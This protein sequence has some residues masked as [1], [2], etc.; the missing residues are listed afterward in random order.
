MSDIENG[1]STPLPI[2]VEPNTQPVKRY[3]ST[4][5]YGVGSSRKP[6]KIKKEKRILFK[7]AVLLVFMLLLTVS[8]FNPGRNIKHMPGGLIQYPATLSALSSGCEGIVMYPAIDP[9]QIGWIPLEPGQA[10]FRWRT[11]PPV[12]GNFNASAWPQAGFISPTN[13]TQ[14][15]FARSMADMY[16]G[17]VY[18]W[19]ARTPSNQSL[20][21][22]QTWINNV[23]PGTPV[24]A[25]QWPLISPNQWPSGINIVMAAW[26]KTEYCSSF[27]A[28]AAEEFR[29]NAAS[30]PA[31]GL[32]LSLKA[33]GPEAQVRTLDLP[34]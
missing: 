3:K 15:S 1:L 12:Y 19:Y 16:R 34:N 13:P 32:G 10:V 33:T 14:P 2:E 26:G 4:P 18:L 25:A 9:K 11:L 8:S 27:N 5:W 20:A 17:W 24:V 30:T 6:A 31:P 21:G 22:L 23:A 28:Q 7:L 29:T